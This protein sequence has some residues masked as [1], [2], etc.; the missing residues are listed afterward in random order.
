MERFEQEAVALV[1]VPT[2]GRAGGTRSVCD[3]TD[4]RRWSGG[5]TVE[6]S[7]SRLVA[8]PDTVL[9]RGCD[10]HR[11]RSGLEERTVRYATVL[12]DQTDHHLQHSH[13]AASGWCR[14]AT[15]SRYERRP[16]SA[17]LA[18]HSHRRRL[19]GRP[20]LW[21]AAV[22]TYVES[23]GRP[24]EGNGRR[25]RSVLEAGRCGIA[26]RHGPDDGT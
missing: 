8:V 19:V 26:H 16:A 2:Y 4:R 20:R 6:E 1:H 5:P 23:V 14:N 13:R 7:H 25:S 12:L 15:E 3:P 17:L 10:D 18:C 24:R 9:R 21:S 22:G 11:V